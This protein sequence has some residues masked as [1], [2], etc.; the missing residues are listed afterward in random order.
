MDSTT[1][2][3]NSSLSIQECWAC[4]FIPTYHAILREGKKF[5][6]AYLHGLFVAYY[7]RFSCSLGEPANPEDI[8]SIRAWKKRALENLAHLMLRVY[9]QM[10][11]TEV[12]PIVDG[13]TVTEAAEPTSS[14]LKSVH[15]PKPEMPSVDG[16]GDTAISGAGEPNQSTSGSVKKFAG[17]P[18]L[19]SIRKS[20]SKA[21]KHRLDP[22]SREGP[23]TKR[24]CQNTSSELAV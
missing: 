24:R 17:P 6:D 7:D 14:S 16:S 22:N 21:S 19:T 20:E 18:K 12:Q 15:P 5:H 4:P 23:L 10:D 9:K 2:P 1:S 8:E 11:L 13:D 3:M